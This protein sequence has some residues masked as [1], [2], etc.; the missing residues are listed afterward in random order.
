MINL[1]IFLY[2][3]YQVFC[4]IY[5]GQYIKVYFQFPDGQLLSYCLA[6]AAFSASHLATKLAGALGGGGRGN[7]IT[8]LTVS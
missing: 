2:I 1:S 7:L 8:T 5:L 3:I 6:A 4:L